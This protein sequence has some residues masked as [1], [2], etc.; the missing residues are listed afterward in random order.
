MA[1]LFHAVITGTSVKGGGA[2]TYVTYSELFTLL[3]VVVAV[4]ALFQNRKR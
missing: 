2:M 3:I 4:V 1:V